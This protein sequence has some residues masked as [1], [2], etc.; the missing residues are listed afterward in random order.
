MHETGMKIRND[1]KCKDR[2]IMIN[3]SKIEKAEKRNMIEVD[4]R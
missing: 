4:L 3:K 2:Q 1:F